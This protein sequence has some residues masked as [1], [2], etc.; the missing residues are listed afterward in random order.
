MCIRPSSLAKDGAQIR[1]TMAN[2]SDPHRRSAGPVHDGQSDRSSQTERRSGTRWPIRAI[3]T[4]AER[5]SGTRWPIRPILT[6]GAQVWYT[7]ANQTDPHRRSA[8]LVPDGQ[9][10]RSSHRRSAGL[11]HD[12]QSDR[13]SQAERRSGTRWPIRPILTGG[14]QVWYP[15][16]NQTDPHRRSA[17]LVPDGQS[18]RYSQAERR[19]GNRWPIRAILTQTERRSGNRWP[20]RAILTQT[21]RRSGTRWPIRRIDLPAPQT[22]VPHVNT[23]PAVNVSHRFSSPASI[24]SLLLDQLYTLSLLGERG[25]VYWNVQWEQ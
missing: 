10:E 3:L 19:S 20:I 17:G 15:M 9:S 8:G 23:Q 16:A 25:R 6:G 4:Q 13:S 18:E 14:A 5:R 11:V 1:Y 2:Q 7:M 21:E 22:V 24:T 12:G